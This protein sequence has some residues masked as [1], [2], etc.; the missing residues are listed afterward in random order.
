MRIF[1]D[2][3]SLVA[4][5]YD[6]IVSTAGRKPLPVAGIAHRVNSV[7]VALQGEEQITIISIINKNPRANSYY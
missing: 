7:S 2:P 6:T 1:E 5:N 4:P 3:I